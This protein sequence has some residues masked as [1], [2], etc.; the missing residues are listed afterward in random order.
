MAGGN[1]S[2][3]AMSATNAFSLQLGVSK[4]LSDTA[5]TTHRLQRSVPWTHSHQHGSMKNTQ[6]V[7]EFALGNTNWRVLSVLAQRVTDILM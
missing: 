6:Q 3:K 5:L 4:V 2:V 7:N 1:S